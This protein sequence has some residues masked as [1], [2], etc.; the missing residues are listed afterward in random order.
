MFASQSAHIELD[1]YRSVS[2][3]PKEFRV[4]PFSTFFSV[5]NQHSQLSL[6]NILVVFQ[7]FQFFIC[8]Q[9]L[10]LSK[11]YRKRPPTVSKR[12]FSQLLVLFFRYSNSAI[13]SIVAILNVDFQTRTANIL[14]CL[15]FARCSRIRYNLENCKVFRR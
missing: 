7:L 6:R 13:R 4:S 2:F 5:L 14:F 11:T 9:G 8:H 12:S 1:P 10:F 3:V 15:N